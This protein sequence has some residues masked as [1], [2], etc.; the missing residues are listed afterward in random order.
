MESGLP[1]LF[2]G[3]WDNRLKWWVARLNGKPGDGEGGF[4]PTRKRD[5]SGSSWRGVLW[6]E[7]GCEPDAW[8]LLIDGGG[9]S[10]G[11]ACV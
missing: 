5:L 7:K 6:V 4:R 9:V 3:Q 1:G 2:L 11:W 10:L 8:V